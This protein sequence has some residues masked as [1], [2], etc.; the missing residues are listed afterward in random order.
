MGGDVM[1]V[2][3][4]VAFMTNE[5]CHHRSACTALLEALY[6]LVSKHLVHCH[7]EFEYFSSRTFH[8]NVPSILPMGKRSNRRPALTT[9][10]ISLPHATSS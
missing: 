8:M 6:V 1:L 2:S 3:K 5:T 10:L 7:Q 9:D 4:A